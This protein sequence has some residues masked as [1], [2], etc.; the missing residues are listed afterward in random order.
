MNIREYL[1]ILWNKQEWCEVHLPNDWYLR[2][3][4]HWF[5]N[6]APNRAR[7]YGLECWER[8]GAK[9]LIADL[10]AC[11]YRCKNDPHPDL[12]ENAVVDHFGYSIIFWVCLEQQLGVEIMPDLLQQGYQ[13][14]QFNEALI[15]RAWDRDP[16]EPRDWAK[17]LSLAF[18]CSYALYQGSLL[19]VKG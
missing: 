6:I 1:K 7:Q 10:S 2:V 13:A 11:F 4:E 17:C 16:V 3:C 14:E 15:A 19:G 5:E 9:A 12:M 18:S 8:L